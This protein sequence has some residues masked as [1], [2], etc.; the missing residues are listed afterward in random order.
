M[1]VPT[2]RRGAPEVAPPPWSCDKASML[3]VVFD[4]DIDSLRELCKRVVNDPLQGRASFQPVDPSIWL[5][6]QRI[7]GFSSSAAGG[8]V[9]YDYGEATFWVLVEDVASGDPH[10]LA[11]YVMHESSVPTAIGREMF[12]FAKEL[13]VLRSAP[14]GAWHEIDVLAHAGTGSTARWSTALRL[15]RTGTAV[16]ALTGVNLM[17]V[18]NR[19]R[20]LEHFSSARRGFLALTSLQMPFLFLR[21]FAAPDGNGCDVQQVVRV[22]MAVDGSLPEL[23]A[24]TGWQL[25]LH[26]LVSH[27]IAADLGLPTLATSTQSATMN[28]R[29]TL[30]AGTV[31]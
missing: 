30:D 17:E 9:R 13:C 14:D 29:F 2:I 10:F 11:P 21:Q 6:V 28:C 7:E 4:A 12:G 23:S 1:N 25:T 26:P 5:T 20:G 22:P 8:G 3:M 24:D 31:L 15:E 27:P 16:A 18:K 19:Q